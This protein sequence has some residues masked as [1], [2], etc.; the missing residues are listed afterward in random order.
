MHT[1][2]GQGVEPDSELPAWRPPEVS[3]VHPVWLWAA[4][5][6]CDQEIRVG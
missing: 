2:A 6:E 1:T 3:G 5:L 4:G